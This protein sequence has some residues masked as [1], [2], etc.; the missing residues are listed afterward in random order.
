ME[1]V[2]EVLTTEAVLIGNPH[3]PHNALID[4]VKLR[5]EGY[6]AATM[7]SLILFNVTNDLVE[8]ACAITPGKKSPSITSLDDGGKAL[9]ALV[10]KSELSKKMDEL[11]ALGATDILAMDLSNS[12]M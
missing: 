2:S 9:S 3:S 10:L 12:R 8:K 11:H 6:I 7:Y 4:K 1:I 5:I